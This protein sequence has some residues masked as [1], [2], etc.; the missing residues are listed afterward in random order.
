MTT[1][2][3]SISCDTAERHMLIYLSVA[4]LSVVC[5][6]GTGCTFEY[7]P[8]LY[9]PSR[10]ACRREEQEVNMTGSLVSPPREFIMSMM[11]PVQ[12]NISLSSGDA[13][14]P[15]LPAALCCL[16]LRR[17]NVFKR[18]DIGGLQNSVCKMTSRR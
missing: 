1:S 14:S 13:N 5:A 3:N 6:R 7:V 18:L 8:R 9:P 17:N 2:F 10:A 15:C 16:P 11:V 4:R 12:K